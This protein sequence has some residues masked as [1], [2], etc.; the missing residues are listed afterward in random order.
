M[1]RS[2]VDVVRTVEEIWDQGKLDELNGFFA[3]DFNANANL[4]GLPAGLEGAKLAH[5]A[6]LQSFPDRRVEVVDIFGEGERV[7]VRCRVTGTNQGGI[8][9][10]GVEPNGKPIDFE[11]ISIYRVKG[12]RIVEHWAI[13]DAL[14]LMTQLGAIPAPG[15]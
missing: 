3:A 5:Q 10:L 15:M 13:N 7:C 6:A 14:T 8:A 1:A 4:P 12:G 2:A 9:P 11:W